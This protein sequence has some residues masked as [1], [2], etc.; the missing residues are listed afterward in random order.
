MRLTPEF[1]SKSQSYLNPLKERELELRGL[2]I[3]VIEN[4]ASHQGTYDVLNLTDNSITVLGNIP[5]SPRLEVIHIAQNQISSISPSLPPNIPNLTTLILTSNSIS[6]LSSLLPL[7]TLTSLRHLSLLQNPI[8]QVDHYRPFIIHTI[9]SGNLRTL[10]F[11][12]IKDSERSN[13]K[14]LFTEP[15]SGLPNALWRKLSAPPMG[16]QTVFTNLPPS[17]PRA[18]GG[19][20][21]G[22]GRLMTPDEK[23]RV[24]EALTRAKTA[25]EVRR[26]ER[27]LA[28]GLIPDGES[29]NGT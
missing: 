2:A 15:D 10:D 5:L 27:M 8:T 6:S 21:G 4:L 13:A 25:E 9:A 22:K 23:K 28:E 11:T 20:K 29:V 1:V 26:L 3:P 16:K 14:Q 7:S 12:R 19:R 18:E 17:G 24:V